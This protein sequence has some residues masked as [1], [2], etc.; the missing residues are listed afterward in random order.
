[1]RNQQ[2]RSNSNSLMQDNTE[3]LAQPKSDNCQLKLLLIAHRPELHLTIPTSHRMNNQGFDVRT[4][5]RDR[6]VV[7]TISSRMLASRSWHQRQCASLKVCSMTLTRKRMRCIILRCPVADTATCHQDIQSNNNSQ[8][9]SQFLEIVYPN[10][11][12]SPA[13]MIL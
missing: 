13:P 5:T 9:A 1:M 4:A 11:I 2:H 10:V 7:E 12:V 6:W 3:V 8:T